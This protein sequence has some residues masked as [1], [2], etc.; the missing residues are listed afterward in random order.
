MQ[1]VPKSHEPTI[2]SGQPGA[3]GSADAGS[4]EHPIATTIENNAPTTTRL[5]FMTNLPFVSLIGGQGDSV[6]G[7]ARISPNRSK[8]T[9]VGDSRHFPQ[10]RVRSLAWNEIDTPSLTDESLADQYRLVNQEL[11]LQDA[12]GQAAA[13]VDR[14]TAKLRDYPWGE[15]LPTTSDFVIFAVDVETT[16]LETSLRTAARPED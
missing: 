11:C 14:V 12:W 4:L 3:T 10:G 1:N 16:R 2:S 9:S 13:M 7:V 5:N 6:A 8:C 15:V